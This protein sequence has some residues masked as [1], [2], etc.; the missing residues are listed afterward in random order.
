[1]INDGWAERD[2]AEAE[3]DYLRG[4]LR[5]VVELRDAATADV[6]RLSAFVEAV[7]QALDETDDSRAVVRIV[8]ALGLLDGGE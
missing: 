2:A 8:A 5:A 1:M 6:V 4:Q 3:A 7:R